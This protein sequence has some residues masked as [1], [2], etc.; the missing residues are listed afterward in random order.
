[1]TRAEVVEMVELEAQK[2]GGIRALS[3]KWGVSAAYLSD[4]RLGNRRPGPAILSQLRLRVVLPPPVEET[5]ER[6]AR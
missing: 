4:I 6:G 1:M 2:A 5:Y 3:R